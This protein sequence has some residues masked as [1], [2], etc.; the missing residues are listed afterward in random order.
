MV[1]KAPFPM[2]TMFWANKELV[3]ELK[4][5]PIPGPQDLR[6]AHWADSTWAHGFERV[7][8]QIV[9]NSGKGVALD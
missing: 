9:A 7:I 8:G 2:G 1:R 4:R 3:D 6:E 5:L